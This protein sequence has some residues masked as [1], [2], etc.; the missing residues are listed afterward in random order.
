MSNWLNAAAVTTAV[1]VTA[2][3][4][5]AEAQLFGVKVEGAYFTN[6]D[7]GTN[8]FAPGN[9][10]LQEFTDYPDGIFPPTQ[11]VAGNTAPHENGTLVTI[12]DTVVATLGFQL[13]GNE[14]IP[15]TATVPYVEFG[16]GP[17]N[18]SNTIGVDFTANGL[19]FGAEPELGDKNPTLG[20]YTVTLTAQ[21][22]GAFDG[23]ELVS[24]TNF[25]ANGMSWTLS[26]DTITI[27]SPASGDRQFRSL[28]LSFGPTETTTPEP[29]TVAVFATGLLGLGLHRYRRRQGDPGTPV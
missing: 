9:S 22:P 17:G 7:P 27:I 12:Q 10:N 2:T 4:S 28:V 29:A 15:V 14:V 6:S 25:L 23:A 19:V 16:A 26:G 5:P 3:A 20:A 8:L 1:L 21:T 24:E 13:V 18:F 11:A